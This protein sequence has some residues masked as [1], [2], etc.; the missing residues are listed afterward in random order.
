MNVLPRS[1]RG[2]AAWLQS[3]ERGSAGLLRLMALVSLR[4]GRPVSRIPLYLI[5]LYFFC[6]APAARRHSLHYLRLALGR[7]P[8]AIERFRQMLYFSTVIHDRV[9]LVNRR[10][11]AFSITVEGED[12]MRSTLAAGRGAF[13]L[14]AH[15]GSF[16][17][18]GTIGRRQPGLQ[19]V[20]AMYE[21]NA[22]KINTALAAINPALK[23]DV[24]ALGQIDSMLRISERLDRGAFVG[25]LGD[26]TLGE[27]PL[28]IVTVLG[29]R[30]ALPTGPMRLA[31]LMGRS[32]IFMLGLY[33]G[34][35]RYHVVFAPVADFSS[36]PPGTR[37]AAVAAAVER[38]AALLEQY[39]RSDPYNWFNFFDF[40]RAHAPAP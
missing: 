13:L 15:M 20:M 40:W 35:N 38:Y 10:D 18:V 21:D 37:A 4:L 27:E 8:R 32:V 25:V 29:A 12:L 1:D 31:A 11:A 14:G 39:C 23:A 26:R 7:K 30:A 16:E 22:R 24:I 17:V 19:V 2:A 34:T 3:G 9:F 6:F 5:A 28:Q 36:L 33:R